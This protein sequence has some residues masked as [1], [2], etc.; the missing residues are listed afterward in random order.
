M[1]HKRCAS[2]KVRT[3]ATAHT[4]TVTKNKGTTEAVPLSSKYKEK[5]TGIAPSSSPPSLGRACEVLP[6][7]R[8]T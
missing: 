7:P 4:Q 3:S 8:E 1:A 6:L 2:L 5:F